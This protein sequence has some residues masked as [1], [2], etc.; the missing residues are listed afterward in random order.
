MQESNSSSKSCWTVLNVEDDPGNVLL[1]QEM[2]KRRSDFRLFTAV[3]GNERCQLAC[4]L[5]PDTVLMD[6]GLPD[7]NGFEALK[8]LLADPATA[9]IPVIALSSDAYP[10][11]IE[12]GIAAGFFRYLTK[13]YK[14]ADLMAAI[15]DALRHAT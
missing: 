1:I 3:T 6:I 13:P 2:F 10:H 11:Q 4:S 15:D 12:H 7:N 9:H 5:L 8:I 14:L